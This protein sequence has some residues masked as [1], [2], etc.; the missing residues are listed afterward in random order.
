MFIDYARIEVRAGK[1]GNGCLSFRREKFV[2]K[3]GP[4]G[5]NGGHG[6]DIIIEGNSHMNTLINFR[7]NKL[8][9]AKNGI[10]G[11]GSNMTGATGEN[12][13]ILVPLGTIIYD[14]TD[15]NNKVKL[16]DVTEAGQQFHIVR[17][18]A[19]GRGNASY[20]NSINQAPRT[21]TPGKDGEE[22]MLELELKLMAD[23]GLVGFPNAGK[24]TLLS[25]IS[26]AKPK[27][28]DYEF[29]TLVPSLGVVQLEG[30]ESFV[31]ADIP[32]LIEGASEGRGL[33]IQFLKHIQ[34]TKVL[35]F[36]I[37]INDEDPFE[38]YSILSNELIQHDATMGEKLHLIVLSKIDTLT[39][40]VIEEKIAKLKI[41]FSSK[42]QE[43]IMAISSVSNKNLDKL[44]R[45]LYTIIQREDDVE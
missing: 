13:V 31:M 9:K 5:G 3:G 43:D 37:D 42:I 41:E 1:G 18:G 36:L 29:T 38:K 7:Y 27:I 25:S 35:L 32:G 16:G 21:F 19:G 10:N 2:P 39:D 15:P 30:F 14:I 11:S 26:A 6:G 24:S 45:R 34:R 40:E 23:V 44:K 4:D 12:N 22:R 28:A 17:G 33:G 8:F 20:A